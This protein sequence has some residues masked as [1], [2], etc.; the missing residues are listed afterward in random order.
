MDQTKPVDYL[1]PLHGKTIIVRSIP[2]LLNNPPS[3]IFSVF[4]GM[5]QTPG[6]IQEAEPEPV[7]GIGGYQPA[8]GVSQ[9]TPA[10]QQVRTD[11]FGDP[12]PLGA[13]A[14]LDTV[15]V[16]HEV[17][18]SRIAFAPDGKTL[19]TANDV[20]MAGVRAGHSQ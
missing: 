13:V 7:D 15:R 19:A 18:V 4:P 14:R 8:Q 20:K 5:I 12:L 3:F 11:C 16:A 1:G 9:S 2:H 10:A 6:M 17:V